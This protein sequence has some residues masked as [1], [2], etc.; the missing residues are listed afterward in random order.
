[1]EDEDYDDIKRFL[2][3]V[4]IS[5]IA[6]YC[7]QSKEYSPFW[8]HLLPTVTRLLQEREAPPKDEE[9]IRAWA[10][11]TE[12]RSR[13]GS[14][15]SVLEKAKSLAAEGRHRES[16]QIL[17]HLFRNTSGKALEKFD[18]GEIDHLGDSL[19]LLRLISKEDEPML[20]E[21]FGQAENLFWSLKDQ[22]A[23]LSGNEGLDDPLYLHRQGLLHRWHGNLI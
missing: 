14:P 11:L 15:F 13:G 23:D 22:T 21:R 16:R 6:E 12:E 17:N 20:S 2:R 1:M 10:R 7:R 19:E 9:A 3:T 4:A 5:T 8:Y 18:A